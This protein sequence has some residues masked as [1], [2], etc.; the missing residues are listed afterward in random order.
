MNTKQVELAA[1]LTAMFD[2]KVQISKIKG[3]NLVI[4]H[5]L[6]EQAYD[7]KSTLVLH[8][9][10]RNGLL[11]NKGCPAVVTTDTMMVSCCD[12][13][14]ELKLINNNWVVTQGVNHE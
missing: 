9:V 4:V 10:D 6:V 2:S 5:S 7:E 8:E 14:V 3:K 1:T 13:M 11:T 12:E